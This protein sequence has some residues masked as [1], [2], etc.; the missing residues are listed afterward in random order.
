MIDILHVCRTPEQFGEIGRKCANI[1]L[2]EWME[3]RLHTWF[4]KVVLEVHKE[5]RYNSSEIPGVLANNNATEAWNKKTKDTWV[6]GLNSTTAE[7]VS[8]AIKE[9]L[10]GD[11]CEVGG[12]IAFTREPLKRMPKHIEAARKLL[13]PENEQ[14]WTLKQEPERTVLFVDSS[15]EESIG[16]RQKGRTKQRVRRRTGQQHQ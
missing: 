16:R 7:V 10:H 8:S 3:T 4:T 12:S 6:S 5:F 2:D 9:L 1:I 11:G 14:Y 15:Y 13:L